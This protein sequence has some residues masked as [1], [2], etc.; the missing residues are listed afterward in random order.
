M[1]RP[2]KDI[3]KDIANKKDA[4]DTCL[5]RIDQLKNRLDIISKC[6]GNNPRKTMLSIETALLIRANAVHIYTIQSQPI[7]M[8]GVAELTEAILNR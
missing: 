8:Y 2:Q 4:V 7:P 5:T 1:R 3:D 6:K